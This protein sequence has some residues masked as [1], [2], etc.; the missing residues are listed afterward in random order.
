[1]YGAYGGGYSDSAVGFAADLGFSANGGT[2]TAYLYGS[3][4]GSNT[5]YTDAAIAEL[6]GSNYGQQAS[7]FA[8]V[9]ATGGTGAGVVNTDI[10]G[11]AAPTYQLYLVGTWVAGY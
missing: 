10:K 4:T 9:V 7:V 11:L 6:Y 2:D 3:S 8:V 5:L 1:M